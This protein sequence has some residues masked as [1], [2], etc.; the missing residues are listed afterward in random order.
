MAANYNYGDTTVGGDKD[1]NKGI[2]VTFVGIQATAS[3][4]V[5]EQAKN[6]AG[7]EQKSQDQDAAT[8][9]NTIG[10]VSLP[11]SGVISEQLQLNWDIKNG[12]PV[13]ELVESAGKFAS[14]TGMGSRSS[15]SGKAAMIGSGITGI[16]SLGKFFKG[17][18]LPP[19]YSMSFSG[20]DPRTFTYTFELVPLS[21]TDA[22][23]IQKVIKI[24]KA[25]SLPGGFDSKN[26][27]MQP[28]LVWPTIISNGNKEILNNLIKPR[29]AAIMNVSVDYGPN[30]AAVYEDGMPKQITLRVDIKEVLPLLRGDFSED[31]AKPQG[32]N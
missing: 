12:N 27:F 2:W 28:Y 32:G 14:N 13:S 24:L 11:I 22:E 9:Y 21:K 23:N 8:D 1:M 31:V 25:W 15:G 18:V 5:I 26:S 4:A 30:Y 3:K 17:T 20:T 29:M 7:A 16:Y 6:A 19:F 10:S